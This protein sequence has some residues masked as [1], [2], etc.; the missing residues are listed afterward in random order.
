MFPICNGIICMTILA[1]A[2]MPRSSAAGETKYDPL[3]VSTEELPTPVDIIVD[4]GTREHREIPLRIYLPVAKSPAPVVLFSHGLGGTNRGSAFLGKH[5]AARGSV[6][7]FM[8]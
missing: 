8:Q 5:W 1:A 3:A 4:D 2:F 7:V 6:P